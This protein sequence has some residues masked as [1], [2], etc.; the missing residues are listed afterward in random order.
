MY[1]ELW[2]DLSVDT[3]RDSEKERLIKQAW[4][5]KRVPMFAKKEIVRL[6]EGERTG[7]RSDV[8]KALKT[9]QK[10]IEKTW[11]RDLRLVVYKAAEEVEAEAV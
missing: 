5:L 2:A 6:I 4:N 11:P 10:Q 7:I 8:L 1:N 9:Y 3:D